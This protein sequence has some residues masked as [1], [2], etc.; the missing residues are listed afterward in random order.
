MPIVWIILCKSYNF[1]VSSLTENSIDFYKSKTCTQSTA[2]KIKKIII[3]NYLWNIPSNMS[4]CYTPIN[5]IMLY[6]LLCP[7]KYAF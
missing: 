5:V 3:N 1:A 2:L 6:L 7:L 4:H